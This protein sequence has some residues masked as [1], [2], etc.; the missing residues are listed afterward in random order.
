MVLAFMALMC[1]LILDTVTGGRWELK[2]LA[3]LAIPGPQSSQDKSSQ[4]RH[5]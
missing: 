1:G 4:D 5:Q 3:Y 2:R